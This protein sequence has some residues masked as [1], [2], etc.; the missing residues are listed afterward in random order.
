MTVRED[1][2]LTTAGM[3]GIIADSFIIECLKVAKDGKLVDVAAK[4]YEIEETISGH[5][6]EKA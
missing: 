2:I 3:V 1:L 5:Q 4:L 6:C